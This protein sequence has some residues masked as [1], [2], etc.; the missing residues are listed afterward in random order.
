MAQEMMNCPF[1]GALIST[2]STFCPYCGQKIA[3]PAAPQQP[4]PAVEEAARRQREQ[5]EAARRQREQEEAARRQREQEEAA[6]RQQEEAARLQR[7]QEEAA[8]R[9]QEEAARLQR[10]Q[11]EAAARQRAYEQQQ[12]YQQQQQAYNQQQSYQQQAYQQQAYQQPY[13]Q[14]G[15]QGPG[16]PPVP[17]FP[18]TSGGS[19]DFSVMSILTEGIPLGIA[20][21][22]TIF[23][24]TILWLLTF[25]IPYLNVGTTIALN[26]M[27]IALA[28]NEAP[29]GPTYIFKDK[30]RKYM[31]EY[32][33]L[34]GLM[35]MAIWMASVFLIIPGI[36]IS[37]AWSQALYLLFDKHLTPMDAMKES[38]EKTYGHKWTIFFTGL[39]F[40]IAFGIFGMIVLWL[41]ITIDVMFLTVI[42]VLLLIALAMVGSVGI[43]AVIYRKLCK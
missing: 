39:V 43:N 5:E 12:A 37:L 2:E 11:E 25:W 8:R 22:V 18:P 10:E 42:A 4:D 35:Y 13:D 41:F 29:E 16:V 40:A 21:F 34:M 33:V 28:D 15:P 24:A 36:V 9:Q 3:K 30:Y 26:T 38:N 32:F 1:C 7:E 14:A 27:P 6:R 31:G 19:S 17:P 23:G 20:N